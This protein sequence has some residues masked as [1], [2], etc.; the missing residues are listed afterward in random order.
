LEVFAKD[1]DDQDE[2][3]ELIEDNQDE[4]DELVEDSE[5]EIGDGVYKW[6]KGKKGARRVEKEPD[7][8]P[9]RDEAE[10]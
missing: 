7:S 5:E 2:V 10:L 6:A 3:D 1:L 9:F 8:D 4:V